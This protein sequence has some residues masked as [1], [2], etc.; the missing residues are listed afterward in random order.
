MTDVVGR[1]WGFAHNLRH[2][3]VDYGDYIEQITYLLFLKM[4]DEQGV[5]LPAETDWPHLRGESG[6]AL[7]EHYEDAAHSR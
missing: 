7:V 5:E 4:A 3:G 2:D 6:V 1:L